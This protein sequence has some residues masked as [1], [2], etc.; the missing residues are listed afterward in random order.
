[1]TRAITPETVN[2]GE[3]L[4]VDGTE[5]KKGLAECK[6]R[7]DDEVESYYRNP[8]FL[9][10][11][12]KVMLSPYLNR[13]WFGEGEVS[14]R[15]IEG[16]VVKLPVREIGLEGSKLSIRPPVLLSGESVDEVGRIGGEGALSKV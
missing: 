3:G 6:C 10:E 1:M 2:D 8:G 12:L 5:G 15:A 7:M 14:S 13:G 9:M 4:E 16:A 11:P